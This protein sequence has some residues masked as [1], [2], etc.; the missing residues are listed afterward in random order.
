M[1]PFNTNTYS[2][3]KPFEKTRFLQT[4][5]GQHTIRILN[6]KEMFTHYL[7]MTNSSVA[8][9]A[10]ECPICHDNKK[11]M[12][13]HPEDFRK[14]P[15]W[16]PRQLKHYMNV[17]DRTLVKICPNCQAENKRG[18]SGQ[19]S[20]TCVECN[21]FLPQD[22]KPIPSDKVKVLSISDTNAQRLNTQEAS[23][24]DKDGNSIPF[25]SCDVIV[26]VSMLKDKKDISL[27]VT[28]D[29]DVVTVP[30]EFLYDLSK[31]LIRLTPQEMRDHLK[32]VSLK[33]IFTA[34]RIVTTT[35][36]EENS[37]AEANED[38]KKKIEALLEG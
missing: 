24:L 1:S 32:G 13:E 30:A 38:I 11:L 12:A 6:F 4:S 23:N 20:A 34:R 36:T 7:P 17:L 8:C 21:T 26:T 3:S 10:E 19:F 18:V 25:T 16:L 2:E 31:V 35:S 29:T 33:D 5:L 9:L 37:V 22:L 27:S 28:R 15:G 14:T